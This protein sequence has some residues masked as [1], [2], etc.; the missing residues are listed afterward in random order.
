MSIDAI[1]K[2]FSRE[3]GNP[4]LQLSPTADTEIDD[5]AGLV[6]DA[7]DHGIP[8]AGRMPDDPGT[9]VS[10]AVA[11]ASY[12]PQDLARRAEANMFLGQ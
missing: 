10:A 12:D 8:T 11:A 7:M 4:G 2:F 5:M 6:I 9:A 3:A 1:R